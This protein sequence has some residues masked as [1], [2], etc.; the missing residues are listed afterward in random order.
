M[1]EEYLLNRNDYSSNLDW[2]INWLTKMKKYNGLKSGRCDKIEETLP[3][4]VELYRFAINTTKAVEYA[5]KLIA[6]FGNYFNANFN[7]NIDSEDYPPINSYMHEC[8]WKNQLISLVCGKIDDFNLVALALENGHETRYNSGKKIKN[9][10]YVLK[11]FFAPTKIIE[12]NSKREK[13]L[14]LSKIIQCRNIGKTFFYRTS[15]TFDEDDKGIESCGFDKFC[16]NYWDKN[17]RNKRFVNI[18]SIKPNFIKSTIAFIDKREMGK[19]NIYESVHN[20]FIDGILYSSVI[21][22]K[23]YNHNKDSVL[24]IV[25]K[26]MDLSKEYNKKIKKLENELKSMQSEF[27]SKEESIKGLLNLI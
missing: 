15:H 16:R 12:E 8:E 22:L 24:E 25:S 1:V 21:P 26:S 10:K 7:Y 9:I 2:K 13:P 3:I 11:T 20:S 5:D 6:G 14:P 4:P 27:Q 23:R 17:C 18:E 19:D